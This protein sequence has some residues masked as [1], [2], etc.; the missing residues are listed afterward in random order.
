MANIAAINTEQYR[1][2]NNKKFKLKTL[3]PS[4]G[5]NFQAIIHI[6]NCLRIAKVGKSLKKG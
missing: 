3:V 1:G 6:I 4:A 2:A 5:A